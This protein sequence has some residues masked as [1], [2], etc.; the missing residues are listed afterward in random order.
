MASEQPLFLPQ[1]VIRAKRDGLKLSDA[2]IERFVHGI[3][4]G[5]VGDA[6]A[7]A[8]AMAVYFQG[9]DVDERVALT[10]AMSLSGSTM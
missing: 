6:Q 7:A 3:T 4:D 10:R 1:E 5:S 2:D 9:M 8:L